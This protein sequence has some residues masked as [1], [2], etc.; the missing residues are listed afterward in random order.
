MKN[1]DQNQWRQSKSINTIDLPQT[2]CSR[3]MEIEKKKKNTNVKEND[4][5]ETSGEKICKIEAGE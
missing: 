5:S 1:N 2:S 4:D 3:N